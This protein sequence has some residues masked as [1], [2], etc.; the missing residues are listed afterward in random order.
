MQWLSIIISI[1]ALIAS[2]Y[3]GI[4]QVKI[5]KEQTKMKNK[6]ELY[7][8][9]EYILLKDV[10]GKNADVRVP[11]ITVRNVGSN[12]VYLEKYIFNGREYPLSREVLPSVDCYNAFHYIYLPTDGTAHVS[13]DVYFYDWDN[14]KW[15]TTGYADYKDGKWDTSY[16]PCERL[17]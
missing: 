7:L 10:S 1:I 9:A 3:I 8:L 15:H 16:K 13:F 17:K 6:V 4:Q 12:I 2:T 5:S 14:E 11:V